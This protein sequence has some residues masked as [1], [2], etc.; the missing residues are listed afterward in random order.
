[1]GDGSQA[2]R[3]NTDN[4]SNN[5]FERIN[6]KWP[7]EYDA[8]FRNFDKIKSLLDNGNKIGAFKVG[9]FRS[10]GGGVYRIGATGVEDAAEIRLYV[11]PDQ[12]GQ[13]MYVLAMGTKK[14]QPGDIKMAKKLV[15]DIRRAEEGK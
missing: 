4:A 13:V 3:I 10:E 2:W 5:R 11:Y 9:F 12:E 6:K 15:E 1:M 8:C 14:S 7:D